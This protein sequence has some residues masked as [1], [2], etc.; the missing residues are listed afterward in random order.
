[1]K[2]GRK[3]LVYIVILSL[4]FQGFD[5]V[6]ND[7]NVVKAYYGS[8]FSQSPEMIIAGSGY[9]LF[10]SKDGHVQ[11]VGND[12]GYYTMGLG[13]MSSGYVYNKPVPSIS[14]VKSIVGGTYAT[15][16][17]LNDG[18]VK[19]W[20]N[21]NFYQMG[22]AGSGSSP[23]LIPGLSNVKQIAVGDQYTMALLN[24]GNVMVW[25]ANS[26]VLGGQSMVN[27]PTLVPSL[28]NVKQI[29]AGWYSAYA[30][31]NDGT[32]KA[33]GSGANGMGNTNTLTTPTTIPNLSNVKKIVAGYTHALA[34]LNDGTVMSWGANNV[35]QLGI[36]STD[37]SKNAPVA[38]PGLSNVKELDTGFMSSVALLNDNTI[39]VWGYNSNG[40]L[41]LNDQ[42]NRIAPTTVSLSENIN[43]IVEVGPNAIFL[44][45]ADEKLYAAGSNNLN[46]LGGSGPGSIAKVFTYVPDV[47]VGTYPFGVDS[48]VNNNSVKVYTGPQ[49]KSSFM[50]MNGQVY[51]WGNNS[52]GILGLGDNVDR[53]SPTLISSLNNITKLVVGGN[54]IFA[55]AQDG[56]VYGWGGNSLGELGTGNTTPQS[57]PMV[58]P[59]LKDAKDIFTGKNTSFAIMSDGSISAWG[60]NNAGQLGLNDTVNRTSP[61][62][63]DFSSFSAKVSKISVGTNHSLALMNDGTVLAWGGNESGQLGLGN[64]TSQLKPIKVT[65]LQNVVQLEAGESYSLALTKNGGVQ[66]WGLNSSGQLGLGNTTSQLTPTTVTTLNNIIN[67]SAGAATSIAITA[68]KSIYTWGNNASGQLGTGDLTTRNTPTL[69]N[70]FDDLDSLMLG[71]GHVLTAFKDGALKSWGSNSN[72]QLGLGDKANR[73]LPESINSSVTNVPKDYVTY[74]ALVRGSNNESVLV[75]SFLDNSSEPLEQNEI[76]LNGGMKE[77]VFQGIPKTSL[78]NGQHTIKIIVS[79]SSQTSDSTVSFNVTDGT[80]DYPL[81]TNITEDS[82]TLR[83]QNATTLN[84][85]AAQPYRF[86]INNT[87]S[88]WLTTSEDLNSAVNYSIPLNIDTSGGKKIVQLANGWWVIAAYSGDPYTGAIFQVSKDKGKN[89]SQLAYLVD[90][91]NIKS[92]PAIT[93]VGNQISGI[94]RYGST[95]R[96]F[97]FDA[98][99]QD[100]NNILNLTTTIDS[101]LQ[102]SIQTSNLSIE[103]DSKGII[104][105]AWIGKRLSSPDVYYA[106]STDYGK[107]WSAVSAV[108]AQ[109]PSESFSNPVLIFINQK[110]VI[111]VKLVAS[112][113]NNTNYLYQ[114]SLTG[115]S[116]TRPTSY[117]TATAQSNPIGNHY[118]YVDGSNIYVVWSSSD[119]SEKN[120]TNIR[121]IKS[122]T[123]GA[124]WNIEDKITTGNTYNQSN[125]VI[126]SDANGKLFVLY[127]GVD[128]AISTTSTNIK[129][130]TLD[131]PIWS[132]TWSAPTTLTNQTSGNAEMPVVLQN[133]TDAIAKD[134]PVFFYRDLQR[135]K[136]A[137]QGSL[138]S[139]AEFTASNLTPNTQYPIS[140]DVKKANG[141][142]DTVNKKVFTLAETPIIS[143]QTDGGKVPKLTF[144]DRNAQGTR[145]QISSGSK[146]LSSEGNW[147]EEPTG[148]LI[149]SKTLELSKLDLHKHYAIKVRAINGDGVSS[150]WSNVEQVGTILT[151]PDAPKN[152]KV[153]PTSSQ[154]TLSWAPVSEATSYEIEI[155]GQESLVKNGQK[156]S[157]VHKG[158]SSNTV[159]FYRVRALKQDIAGDW[160]EPITT[161]TLLVAPATPT[162]ITATATTKSVTLSWGAVPNAFGYEVEWDG[163]VVST[164]MLTSF[165]KK[166]LQVSSQHAYRVR[167][168]NAGGTSAW[169]PIQYINTKNIAPAAPTIS[170]ASL[171]NTTATLR[172]DESLDASYYEVKADGVVTVLSDITTVTFYGL[173]ENSPH[174]YLIRAVNEVGAS[175]WSNAINVTTYLL[176]TP[177]NFQKELTDKSILLKWDAV[178]GASKYEV[179]ANGQLYTVTEPQYNQT[180]L[181]SDSIYTYRI[182]AVNQSGTSSWTSDLTYRTL[183][184]KPAVPANI[185]A[186]AINRN[187]AISWDPVIGATGYDVELDGTVIVDNFTSTSYVDSLLDP[188]TYH[189]YRVRAR[190][191]AVEGDWSSA[192]KVTLPDK[193]EIPKDINVSST[194]TGIVKIQWKAD[195]TAIRYE[196]EVDGTVQN[197]GSESEFIH[198]GVTKGTEHKYRI[199][200][201]N[202]SGTGSWSGYILNNT[203]TARLV[204]ST[205]VDLS[206][207][208]K[209]VMDFSKYTLKVTYDPNAIEITDL[210][211]WTSS[212][213][214]TVGR[215]PNSSITVTEFTPGNIVFT[216]DQVI[217]SNESWS[218]VINSIA[219]KAKVSGGSPITYSVIE[220][221]AKSIVFE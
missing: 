179:Q 110:P 18:T 100:N 180:N 90:I 72:G 130:M 135:N 54:Q 96:A 154:V 132:A 124:T 114:Y 19:V 131:G 95:I 1:M 145:Y 70:G 73:T 184:A 26:Y 172:W 30:L 108:T 22:G 57:S 215:I 62:K 182:R 111:I 159:H 53:T 142:I 116:W 68:N 74:K 189:R 28:T 9:S 81:L 136:T 170:L 8:E 177:V 217:A 153:K 117:I 87:S 123:A 80:F 156:L 3:L 193:P 176:S 4:V 147:I 91:D 199:R 203:M 210:S 122:S 214:L 45:T 21:N 211:N 64:T 152:L 164:G 150:N 75:K 106:S 42:T 7:K 59:L 20:G 41:G 101:G 155:D 185:K 102:D 61:S 125:P 60:Y 76:V 127:S 51:S 174:E 120:A 82:I 37:S 94:I 47:Q 139:G 29:A 12:S 14:N 209:D 165:I 148:L 34:L 23:S 86:V 133:Q 83:T 48:Q 25:G 171:D 166:K 213:E 212:K 202:L 141:Q 65:G 178:T 128:P 66:S 198:R 194:S 197:A 134:R 78:S 85:L 162:S 27:T 183:P 118:V 181:S 151:P 97:S 69:L 89:W 112:Y 31:L 188:F 119:P 113:N 146:Y 163:Q 44:Q 190:T 43:H 67:I 99:L 11:A 121:F 109:N 143:V 138:Q 17:V 49:S 104:H 195:P 16:A 219:M 175:S 191:D 6:T 32:V 93:A 201:I 15:Y 40:Q 129:Q 218:G 50:V 77:V 216:S 207:I 79:S 205:S 2:K 158:L 169:S 10:L 192:I 206:L 140:L 63:V 173:K 38:V 187:V 168:M 24:D 84:E 186:I 36:N 58:L 33:W 126:T 196:V 107:N 149:D 144:T 208:G 13:N 161:R 167:A 115:T 52:S 98:L 55:L 160:S 105:A 56:T 35:G 46:Q 204:K 200:T 71:N 88:E 103:T 92:A 137:M 221:P 5:F 220:S 157:Y 39:K